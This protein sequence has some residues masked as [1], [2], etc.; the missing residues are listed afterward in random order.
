M[1]VNFKLFDIDGCAYHQYVQGRYRNEPHSQWLLASNQ[2]L[3]Q[4]IEE[5][6]NEN[7]YD[8][9]IL[10]YGTNRQD[11][12]VD[13]NN[14]YRG[15]SLAPALPL[16]QSYLSGKLTTDVV[17]EPF[18]MA[19]IYG[20]AKERNGIVRPIQE[21]NCAAGDSY[22]NILRAEYK[23]ED[24]EHAEWMFDDSKIS[25]IYAQ[26]HRVASLHPTDAEIVIDFYDDTNS[27]LKA[28]SNFFSKHPELLPSNVRL[29]I[30]KY[31]GQSLPVQQKEI[32]GIGEVDRKYDWSVRFLSSKFYHFS[33]GANEDRNIGTAERL[34]EYHEQDHYRSPYH[35]MA[36]YVCEDEFNS[37]EFNLMRNKEIA[38]L[39]SNPDLTAAAYT[40]AE[41]LYAEGLIPRQLIV[42]R[43]S[44]PDLAAE[45][46][47][48]EGSISE[49]LIGEESH[50]P[51]LD[52]EAISVVTTANTNDAQN[53]QL[54]QKAFEKAV[55]NYQQ[56]Y[57][58]EHLRGPNGFF[59]LLRHGEKGQNRAKELNAE[60]QK[61]DSFDS[62]IIK[63][64]EFLS[65]SATRYHRHSLA[66][67]LLDE[68]VKHDEL[69]WSNISANPSNLYDQEMVKLKISSAHGMSM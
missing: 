26:A 38:K 14:S 8:K 20:R 7:H 32:Q 69:G 64:N 58:G 31:N 51:T 63:V 44:K 56:W 25:L 10:A 59:S 39:Q 57:K 4:Q 60:I 68:L 47:D 30:K 42:E 9:L 65:N 2:P 24:I 41:A 50:K 3:L 34:Q 17:I 43:P 27:I 12:F 52:Q 11:Y 36:M 54:I 16:F 48:T 13:A 55:N 23:H 18:L 45:A 22:K 66:S 53:L 5:E 6:V 33:S 29:N 49:Q 1:R 61:E 35:K 15:G 37:D 40:T 21:R 67:F 19:D 62:A 28:V 46:L